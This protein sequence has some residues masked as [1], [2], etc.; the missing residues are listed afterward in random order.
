MSEKIL[1]VTPLFGFSVSASRPAFV[2]DVLS[3]FGEVEIVTT[4]FNH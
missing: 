3:E 1:V 2:A 4:D